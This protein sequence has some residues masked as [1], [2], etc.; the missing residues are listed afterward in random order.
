MCRYLGGQVGEEGD[1]HLLTL[2]GEVLVQAV[3]GAL[4]VINGRLVFLQVRGW[5]GGEGG[6]RVRVT[7][8]GKQPK[9]NGVW[10]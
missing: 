1:V 10:K 4:G 6:V 7:R 3:G 5:G 9:I 8:E 2:H